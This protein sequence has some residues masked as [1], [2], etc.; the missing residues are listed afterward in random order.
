MATL[1]AGDTLVDEHEPLRVLVI[2]QAEKV[3]KTRD[4]LAV[5]AAFFRMEE[6]HSLGEGIETCRNHR[7]EVVVL[8][9]DLPDAWPSDVFLRFAEQ[10]P[11]SSIIVIAESTLDK[12]S[13]QGAERTPFCIIDRA[14]VDSTTIR[15]LVASAGILARTLRSLP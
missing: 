1:L 12:F 3:H 2:D 10:T 4:A 7:N 13:L 14:K 6:C 8:A 11:D 9:T 5:D 15:R